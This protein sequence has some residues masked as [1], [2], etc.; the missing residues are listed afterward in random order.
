MTAAAQSMLM[1]GSPL[2][3]AARILQI[4]Q[5]CGLE[6]DPT[7]GAA[8]GTPTEFLEENPPPYKANGAAPG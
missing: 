8:C 5:Q 3:V 1:V 7:R 4:N 2:E 6:D